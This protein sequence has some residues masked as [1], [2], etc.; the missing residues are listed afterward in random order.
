MSDAD[1][2]EVLVRRLSARLS[3]LPATPATPASTARDGVS[4]RAGEESELRSLVHRLRA[5]LQL[6]REHAEGKALEVARNAEV[7]AHE[8]LAVKADCVRAHERCRALE[9]ELHAARDECAS[10]RGELERE[11]ECERALR[12]QAEATASSLK[13]TSHA[14]GRSAPAA[15][16]G[17]KPPVPIAPCAP[18]ER[19]VALRRLL[20]LSVLEQGKQSRRWMGLHAVLA[21]EGPSSY[22]GPHE[23]R[24]ASSEVCSPP[25]VFTVLDDSSACGTALAERA[26]TNC[27]ADQQVSEVS[28][29]PQHDDVQLDNT[30]DPSSAQGVDDL[31]GGAGSGSGS[32]SDDDDG[33]AEA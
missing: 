31:F 28:E 6:E 3:F 20:G 22:A 33:P 4:N 14:A 23:T 26:T 11:L 9:A 19:L 18:S 13:E 29:R 16:A 24:P 12:M 21:G 10:Q 1:D 8:L 2:D 5:Q 30:L 17:T 15:V 32:G 27:A 7:T 25:I